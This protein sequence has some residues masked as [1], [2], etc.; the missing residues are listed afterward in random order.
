MSRLRGHSSASGANLVK[1]EVDC[2]DRF[3]QTLEARKLMTRAT[4][5]ELRARY[6]QE[7]LDASK[8]I[9]SEP[10]PAPSDIYNHVFSDTNLVGE[11]S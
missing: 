6:N 7:L 4:C 9:A 3:E 2:I 5:D 8:R 10:A 1:G 11:G